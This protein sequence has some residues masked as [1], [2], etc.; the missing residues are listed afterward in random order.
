MA[1]GNPSSRPVPNGSQLA[2]RVAF[3]ASAVFIVLLAILHVLKPE[4]DPSW[5]FISE[6]ELGDHGWVMRVAF[7]SLALSCSGLCVTLCSQARSIGGYLG[8]AMLLLSAIGMT[9]AGI[10][11]PDRVNRLHEVGAMLDHLPF[12]ALLINWS[13][14]RNG[15]WSSARRML[16]WTAGLPLLGL[17]IFVGSMIVMLPRHGGQPGPEVLVGWPNRIMILAHCAWIMPVAWHAMH[18]E[19]VADNPMTGSQQ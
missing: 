13:L 15:A 18:L 10:H 8:L 3:V 14:S 12:A 19:R 2:A 17:V 9:I 7:F 4:L 1:T 6:Y 5:R 16:R 11:V